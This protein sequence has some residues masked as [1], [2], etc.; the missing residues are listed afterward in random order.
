L[1]PR[2]QEVAPHFG[3]RLGEEQ[4]DLIKRTICQGS[5]DD[6]LKLFIEQC[7][8]TRLDPFAKQIFAV[9]RWDSKHKRDVMAIQTSI[10]GYRLIAER[11]GE[12]EG[13]TDTA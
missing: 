7:R 3:G 8:R 9:K 11:T 10:D 4:V 2:G 12:Y 5:T 6:E 13:Q 1:V